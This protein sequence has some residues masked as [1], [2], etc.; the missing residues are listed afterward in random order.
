MPYHELLVSASRIRRHTQYYIIMQLLYGLRRINAIESERVRYS[1][2]MNWTHSALTILDY[3]DFNLDA[4]R[5][6]LQRISHIA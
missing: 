5:F 4:A 3:L 6:I 1:V 2:E